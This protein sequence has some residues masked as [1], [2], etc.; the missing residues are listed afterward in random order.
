M[1]LV[2]LMLIPIIGGVL[3]WIFARWSLRLTHWI[4]LAAMAAVLGLALGIWGQHW[5]GVNLSSHG[6]WLLMLDKPWIPRLGIRFLLAMDGISLLLVLLT[7]AVGLLA[8]AA[9][10]YIVEKREGFFYF[11][12]LWSF[13]AIVGVFL[14][15]DLFLFYFL[16]ELMIV[17]LYF[18]IAL[19]GNEN[20]RY[21][22]IK[23]FIFTQVGGLFLL[24][25]TLGL[26]FAHG[27]LTGVYTFD[28][29]QLLG[30]TMA[31]A[32]AFWLMLGFFFAFIVK[33]PAVPVHPW[34]PD[35][36]TQAPVA[37][38]VDLAGLVLKVGAYGLLRFTIPLFPQTA[39]AFAPAAMV[40]AV[41]SIYY[42]AILAFAQTDLKRLIAYT[43]I[44]HM[45]FVLLGIFAWNTLSLQGALL[46]VISHGITT[47]AL[48]ILAGVIA[49]RIHESRSMDR[50]GG[51][52]PVM[53]HVAGSGSFFA[54]A[55]LGLP[56]FGN[57]IGE[58][59][60]LFGAF[61]V[62]PVFAILATGGFVLS[63]IYALR[64]LQRVFFGPL[65]NPV[66]PRDMTGLETVLMGASMA[67]ILWLGLYPQSVLNRTESAVLNLQR[68]VHR[69]M[70]TAPA[71]PAAFTGE[72]EAPHELP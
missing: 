25:A 4:S 10:W 3:A 61:A 13:G 36:H 63:V 41:I 26:Y 48:F 7:G 55:A 72:K 30:T 32:L 60:V 27:R 16:W 22:A 45:G 62:S 67:V 31:P 58:I 52:W 15:L 34:L 1:I 49:R 54:I 59:L 65:T 2:W 68:I 42:G 64:I 39:L 53:P 50:M 21:A 11:M 37:G 57:F 17:P 33:L 5:D 71:T 14:A 46:I 47:S 66:E 35:A 24:L 69:A 6:V 19:W 18:L 38:S 56:G 9:S 12:L 51:F 43:S 40:L 20:R 44:S 23:F 8:V 29:F 70:P 28:Y